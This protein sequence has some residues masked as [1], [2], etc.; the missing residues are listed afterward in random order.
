MAFD[1]PGD[2][3]FC[4]MLEAQARYTHDD[5]KIGNLLVKYT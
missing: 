3:S 4:P 1:Q 5:A 2:A